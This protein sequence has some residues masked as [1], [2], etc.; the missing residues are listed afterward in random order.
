MLEAVKEWWGVL[1]SAVLVLV[2][3]VRLESRGLA[4]EKELRRLW[5]QRKEDLAEA[6]A[7]RDATND[8]L[9]EMR[10]DIKTLLFRRD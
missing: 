5:A 10:G 3:L 1:T 8:M 6:K 2:W 9:R 7:A 4:N